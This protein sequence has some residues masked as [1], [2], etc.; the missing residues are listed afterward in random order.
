VY[1]TVLSCA[2]PPRYTRSS[3]TSTT[4]PEKSCSHKGAEGAVAGAGLGAAPHERERHLE[5]EHAP[6][7]ESPVTG[8]TM[9]TSRTE[10]SS[11]AAP[12]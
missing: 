8:T 6:N 9:P 4:A 1:I 12:K 2:T 5:R 3:T 10:P 11:K 7:R